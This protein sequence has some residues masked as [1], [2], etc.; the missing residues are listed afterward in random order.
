MTKR[1]SA[2]LSA[3]SLFCLPL[4]RQGCATGAPRPRRSGGGG[5]G[6]GGEGL[7]VGSASFDTVKVSWSAAT[8]LPLTAE[9]S[10]VARGGEV[11]GRVVVLV[12]D[13]GAGVAC[14]GSEVQ[15]QF[16][17]HRAAPGTGPG[18]GKPG[19]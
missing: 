19:V 8:P 12:D 14:M 2:A 7:L 10:V 3:V 16:A 13:P 18:G 4:V 17:V 6:A 11:A 1:M 15:W 9:V 5:A